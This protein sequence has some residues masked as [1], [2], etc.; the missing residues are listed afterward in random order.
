MSGRKGDCAT[1]GGSGDNVRLGSATIVSIGPIS[2]VPYN[3]SLEKVSPSF[4]PKSPPA[5]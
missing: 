2:S 1:V 5:P 3:P 4:F